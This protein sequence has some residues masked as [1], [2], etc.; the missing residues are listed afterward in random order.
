MTAGTRAGTTA[1]SDGPH[2]C[3]PSL[4]MVGL[5]VYGPTEAQSGLSPNVYEE[6]PKPPF[7]SYLSSSELDLLVRPDL[8]PQD[9]VVEQSSWF[10]QSWQVVQVKRLP[11]LTLACCSSEVLGSFVVS[12]MRESVEL[13][14]NGFVTLPRL[15]DVRDLVPRMFWDSCRCWPDVLLRAVLD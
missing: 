14:R 7:L 4:F 5:P 8:L 6:P 13:Q 3:F 9:S 15:T 11:R 10:H 2:E 12:W 1:V